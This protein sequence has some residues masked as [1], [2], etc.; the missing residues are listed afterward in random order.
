MI[1]AEIINDFNTILISIIIL[2]ITMV[3]IIL[4]DIIHQ[5]YRYHQ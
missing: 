1:M 2:I 5:S 3:T 4:D